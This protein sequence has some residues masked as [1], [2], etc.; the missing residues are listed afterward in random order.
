MVA[1]KG[2]Y[3]AANR[4]TGLSWKTGKFLYGPLYPYMGSSPVSLYICS[5]NSQLDI[6]LIIGGISIR[7]NA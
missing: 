7:C 4:R 6:M 5:D 1:A 3:R 2:Q